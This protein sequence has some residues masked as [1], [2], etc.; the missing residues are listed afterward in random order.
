[1][2]IHMHSPDP[3]APHYMSFNHCLFISSKIISLSKSYHL[4][5]L[6]RISALFTFVSNGLEFAI[7]LL[8]ALLALTIFS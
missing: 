6:S 3:K 2:T 7:S 1:M 8:K 4:L 5:S